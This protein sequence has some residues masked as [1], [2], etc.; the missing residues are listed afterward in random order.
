M[1][2]V[3]EKGE[4]ARTQVS[5]KLKQIYSYRYE[6]AQ[7]FMEEDIPTTICFVD[8]NPKVI[9]AGFFNTHGL[10]IFDKETAAVSTVLKYN[11]TGQVSTNK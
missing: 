9:V 8:G 4:G 1:W 11:A 2:S 5:A 7:K 6:T 3:F 10:V